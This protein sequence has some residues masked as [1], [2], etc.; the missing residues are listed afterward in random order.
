MKDLE[1]SALGQ[2][3][4]FEMQLMVTMGTDFQK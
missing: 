2:H 3:R 1:E 4:T